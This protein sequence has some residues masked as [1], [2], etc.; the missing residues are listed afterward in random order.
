MR[1][2]GKRDVDRRIQKTE[3]HL[4]E[5]LFTLILEKPYDA[6]AVKEILLR[7]D[8]GRSTFYS[9]YRDKDE[10]LVSAI[11]DML[12]SGRPAVRS[13]SPSWHDD[14]LWF[15]LPVF[16]HLDQH[17]R[18][19][20]DRMGARSRAI[21]HG[22]LEHAVAELVADELK[23]DRYAENGSARIPR[24]LLARHVAATFVLVLNWWVESGSQLTA[25]EIDD[26]FRSLVLPVVAASRKIIIS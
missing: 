7:A 17:R 19:S 5:A 24:E 8:V 9:H 26:H 16:T 22:H 13:P 11:E 2:T 21:L 1:S 3:R 10:L 6:I 18:T 4:H 14:V 23:R 25:A 15:S 20:E 12:R